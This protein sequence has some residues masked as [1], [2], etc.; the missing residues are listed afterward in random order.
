MSSKTPNPH[1][2]ACCALPDQAD[3]RAAAAEVRRAEGEY[4]CV[5]DRRATQPPGSPRPSGDGS[6]TR[7]PLLVRRTQA[8]GPGLALRM[9]FAAGLLALSGV[10]AGQHAPD[11][12]RPTRH[13]PIP[14]RTAAGDTIDP[15]H[16]VNAGQ[17]YSPRQTCG[18]SKCHDYERITKGTH[19]RPP[20]WEFASRRAAGEAVDADR[21]AAARAAADFVRAGEGTRT[22]FCPP[23]LSGE[24][25][26]NQYQMLEG[27]SQGRLGIT[28]WQWMLDCASF[29]P[30]G[31]RLE[32]DRLGRRYDETQ[33][34]NPELAT[35]NDADY[36]GAHWAAAGV[37]E[38]D[39]LLCHARTYDGRSRGDALRAGRLRWAATLGAGLG[40][41][42]TAGR[43]SPLAAPADASPAARAAPKGSPR[44]PL[45]D[46]TL[47]YNRRFFDEDGRAHLEIERR[48]SDANCLQCHGTDGLRARGLTWDDS[49]NGDIH[50]QQKMACIDCHSH[51]L[52]HVQL[53]ATPVSRSL[54]QTSMRDCAGCH[55]TGERGATI[56]THGS[57]PP[58][59]LRKLA[60][61]SCHVPSLG[62]A[63]GERLDLTDGTGRWSVRGAARLGREDTWYPAYRRDNG[64]ISPINPV[65]VVFFG[66]RD[67]SGTIDPL[68][69][70]EQK[71][72]WEQLK[73]I[74]KDDDHDGEL[75]VNR[76]DEIA[77]GL[78]AAREV[79][80]KFKRFK[81][82]AP[83]FIKGEHV[84]EL[85]GAGT[86]QFKRDHKMV[87]DFSLHHNVAPTK[88]AL[89][90][91]GCI[92]CHARDG[93]FFARTYTIDPFGE[94]GKKVPEP[95]YRTVG[96]EE[97]SFTVFGIYWT[98]ARPWLALV[99]LLVFFMSTLHFT[100]F[101]PHDFG[102]GPVVPRF[103]DHQRIKRFSVFERF[104]H[105]TVVV[106]FLF[107]GF[108]GLAFS[109]E[110]WR[111]MQLVFGE[112]LTPRVWH[113]WLGY[114]FGAGIVLMLIRWWRDALF[115]RS[116]I[117]WVKKMGGYLGGHALVPAERFNAG[118]KLY[119]WTVI[120]GGGLLT[121][122]GVVL[123]FADNLSLEVV[124]I[125]AILHNFAGMFGVAG[126]MSHIY[127]S[128]AANP[129]TAQAAFAGWVTKGWARLHHPLWY[130][131]LTGR[132]AVDP[133]EKFGFDLEE[134]P[135]HEPPKNEPPKNEPPKN[136]DEKGS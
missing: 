40:A 23:L 124:L 63:A 97:A 34:K 6:A 112:N 51:G 72:V 119:F 69:P 136:S 30:G 106:T 120:F 109:F 133:D 32:F 3:Q 42:V 115:T 104:L 62:R 105:L 81:V 9:V 101:G 52:E 131:K 95:V 58:S 76:N 2:G 17:P 80:T 43:P 18:Q 86:V 100:R 46:V 44:E 107:L 90:A 4:R 121:A 21:T 50:N 79:L 111:W 47:L 16:G 132:K 128:T 78:R 67:P 49:H 27:E 83:V 118:Q 94:D 55:V 135:K 122:S 102:G 26:P 37:V 117:G 65:T 91:N 15:L 127:L 59:H 103:D 14:L 84:Y 125:S 29:H 25:A 82:V 35:K 12:P 70:D 130:E 56:A 99:L 114:I 19:F 123:A 13:P 98:L 24:K 8:R 96:L 36:G 33:R 87:V 20:S 60:C 108:T 53:A 85:D 113:T 68:F 134:H 22:S 38:A 66:N 92:D 126:V 31:G 61:E 48:P 39:C 28:A 93:T 1:L 110:G 54:H 116:D 73:P 77:A 41:F 129:G 11:R 45:L 10:A 71:L 7:D 75:E 74:L 5:L 64:K 88:K 89:G 57:I